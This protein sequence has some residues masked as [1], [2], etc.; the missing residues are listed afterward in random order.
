MRFASRLFVWMSILAVLVIELAGWAAR[1]GQDLPWTPL[2][3]GLPAG[4]TTA[5]R[6]AALRSQPEFCRQLLADAGNTSTVAPSRLDGPSCGYSDGLRVRPSP[7]N[8]IRFAPAAPIVSC[9]VAAGLWLWQRDVVQPAAARFLGSTVT[10]I[11]HAGSY[12][13]R[14]LYGR[15]DGDWSE[16]ASANAFDVLGFRFANG[17]VIEVVRDWNGDTAKARFLRA[18][19][20]G[21]CRSFTTVLSPDYNI[22]HRDHLHLDMASRGPAGWRACR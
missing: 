7:I 17:A 2:D 9:P 19:R 18:V 1:H 16:H 6:L 5:S 4:R 12:S 15:E 22:A 21:A 10:S 13:C 3:L 20:D 8:E 14:R 11:D